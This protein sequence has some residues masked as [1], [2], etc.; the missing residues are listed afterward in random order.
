MSELCL[1]SF[2]LAGVGFAV[3]WLLLVAGKRV[4]R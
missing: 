2:T 1:L 3:L 4:S